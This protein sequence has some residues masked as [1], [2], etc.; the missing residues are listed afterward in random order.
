M[1]SMIGACGIV[2]SMTLLA[3]SSASAVDLTQQQRASI[4]E[5]LLRKLTPTVGVFDYLAF[6]L[7]A[8]G[9]VTLFGEVRDATLKTH[10]EEDAKKVEGVKRIRNQI[11]VLPPLPTDDQIRRAV[12]AA[13]YH[14]PG[15]IRYTQQAVPP[16]HIIVK[17][18]YVRLEGYVANKLELAQM[19]VA[20]KGVP[21][22]FSV[23]N[24]VRTDAEANARDV[25]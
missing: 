2:L 6:Q 16:V 15:F 7:D 9:T 11:E 8:K 3:V 17:N 24:N 14:Q 13:I 18:G 12:Y 20:A 10:A 22:V 21:G 1:R 19:E 25:R 5:T 4:E 23:S